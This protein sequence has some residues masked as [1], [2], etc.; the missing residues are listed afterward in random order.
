MTVKN[1]SATGLMLLLLASGPASAASLVG[2]T[3]QIL[4][5]FPTLGDVNTSGTV[6]VDETDTDRVTFEGG[7][8]GH[9]DALQ[10]IFFQPTSLTFDNGSL[11]PDGGNFI[12]FRDLDFDDG[13][14]ITGV[15]LSSTFGLLTSTDIVFG[16]DFVRFNIDGF[17]A[18]AGDAI[19]IDITTSSMEPP[20]L[21][22]T[23]LGD[24]VELRGLFPTIDNVNAGVSRIVDDTDTDRL[25]FG[26]HFAHADSLQLLFVVNNAQ[27]FAT[28]SAGEGGGN[29]VSFEDLD[30]EDGSVLTGV[31]LSSTIAGLTNDDILFGE[32]FVRFDLSGVF[33]EEPGVLAIDLTTSSTVSPVPLVS[34]VL[35][36]GRSVSVGSTA[37]AFATI[38]NPS[39]NTGQD[40]QIAIGQ[41][42]INADFF[43]QATDPLTNAAVGVANS[44][45]PIAPGAAQSFVFGVTPGA[46]LEPT[47]IDLQFSC[48]NST[49]ALS[50]VGLNTLLLSASDGPVADVVALS[51]TV[52]GDGIVRID[53]DSGAGA[54]SVASINLGAS[55]TLFASAD[56]GAAELP[57]TLSMCQTDPISGQCINPTVPTTDPVSVE[58]GANETPTI[59]VF[60]SS[61]ES[62][63]LDPANSR[64]F[65]RFEDGS[66]LSR[67]ATSVAVTVE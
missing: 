41:S 24:R 9:A 20:E 10:L 57:V 42:T 58:I 40:C 14:V 3:I 61:S 54:F 11:G 21:E 5:L 51:A 62:I 37:T 29:F 8:I 27:S 4:N 22:A 30:F 1:L 45:V 48:V 32:D 33:V 25:S 66:G 7:T 63:P 52:L 59:A 26:P 19:I 6:V 18:G 47:E 56:T 39:P 50:V 38:I 2:D 43:Y 60:A 67:G 35:P 55:D 12:E 44:P 49:G 36:T 46:E 34:S 31:N 23:L 17:F 28:G 16:D 15:R 53:S 13:S 64:V 65:V